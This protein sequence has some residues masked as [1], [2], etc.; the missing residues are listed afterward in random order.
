MADALGSYPQF[1]LNFEQQG[2]RAKDLL[3]AA[4]AGEVEAL[5]RFKSPPRLAE[6]QYLIAR[7]LR[8]D[9]WASMKRHISEMTL[10]REAMHASAPDSD[11]PTL[12]IRC[13]HDLQESLKEAGFGGDYYVDI[14]PYIIGPVR[15]GSGYLEQ[16][17]RHIVDCYGDQFDPP[18]DYEGQLRSLEDKER[19]LHDSA[20]Y[21]RVVLWFEHDVTDQLSL[22]HLLG[23]YATHRRP[24]RLELVSIS[25][26]PGARRFTGLGELPPEALRLLWTTRKPVSAAQLRLGLDAWRALANP[27]PLPLAAIMRSA[28]PALPLL[29]RAL[30]RHLRELPSGTNGLSLTEEM[31]LTLMAQPL[32]RWGGN[33]NLAKIYSAMH[34]DI[35]PLPGQ[36]DLHVRDR[37]LNMEGAS[38]RVFERRAGFGPEGNSRPP[39]TDI[40]SITDLGRAV[41][42]GGFDFMSLTP[43]S[44]WVGGVQIGAGMPDWRWDYK[45][46]DAVRLSS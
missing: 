10:A 19:E 32:P 24:S 4:R 41:L 40:L 44:R 43:P 7:E 34:W 45:A 39:W 18:L 5:A 14:Y 42:K 29:A 12:H 35:D 31:A 23:H 20:D 26:F 3:K 27:D 38:A 2:K 15:E 36:G 28:T 1:R 21:E 25:D 37:V 22:I 16:R 8:F 33:V 13:G 9:N 17:A 6:A 46:G 30:H 11:L